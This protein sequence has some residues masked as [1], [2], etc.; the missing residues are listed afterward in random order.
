[1][2]ARHIIC[3]CILPGDRIVEQQDYQDDEEHGAGWRLLEYMLKVEAKNRAVFVTRHYDGAHIGSI[4]FKCIVNAAKSAINQKPYNSKS[5]NFQFS[6]PKMGRG[7]FHK[8]GKARQSYTATNDSEAD[9]SDSEINF[10]DTWESSTVT[11]WHTIQ[12][13]EA[14]ATTSTVYHDM[15]RP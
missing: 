9:G 12:N 10:K 5:D 3:A 4:R 15:T 14:Q 6:W 11:R 13:A 2:D 1:M 7:G 8:A